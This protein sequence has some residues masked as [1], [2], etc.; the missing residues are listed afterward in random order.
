MEPFCAAAATPTSISFT[1]FTR[2][3]LAS[4]SAS[5]SVSGSASGARRG[6]MVLPSSLEPGTSRSATRGRCRCRHWE[7]V[8][9]A[10]GTV[11]RSVVPSATRP[12]SPLELSSQTLLRLIFYASDPTSL[13]STISSWCSQSAA[14]AAALGSPDHP[15]RRVRPLPLISLGLYGCRRICMSSSA[16]K[17]F[18]GCQRFLRTLSTYSNLRTR[19]HT[20]MLSIRT[21]TRNLL[22]SALHDFRSLELLNAGRDGLVY[23]S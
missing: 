3:S 10:G 6:V 12:H 7:I 16:C 8:W 2:F 18:W 14:A 1:S 21:R 9:R 22:M 23:P 20:T 17:L 13:R 15:R 11:V 5:A 4:A 19:T